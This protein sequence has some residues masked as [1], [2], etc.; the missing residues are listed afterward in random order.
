MGDALG[1]KGNG[2]L[3]MVRLT[4]VERWWPWFRDW[5]WALKDALPPYSLV[6]GQLDSKE[7][8]S[9]GKF[10]ILVR[11]ERIEIDE[12]TFETLT[13]GESI[14]VRYTKGKRAISIDRLVPNNGGG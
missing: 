2:R 12:A 1:P 8:D 7:T 5:L 4:P 9:T 11:A 10:Y 3:S 6:D 14:R 13:V